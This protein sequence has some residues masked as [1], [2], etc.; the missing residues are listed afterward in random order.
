MGETFDMS[1]VFTFLEQINIFFCRQQTINAIS[2]I[3]G[4]YGIQS[5]RN[6]QGYVL[7]LYIYKP[8][9]EIQASINVENFC[10]RNI[11]I[12]ILK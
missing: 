7:L 2:N 4:H 11:I 6:E 3:K 8:L 1:F 10:K 5:I 9:H 12:I